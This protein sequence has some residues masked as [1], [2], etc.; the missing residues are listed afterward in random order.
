[1]PRH[2]LTVAG[3]AMFVVG[4]SH[5]NSNMEMSGPPTKPAPAPEMKK[6]SR[7]IGTWT[8]DAEMVGPM[9]EQM[10]ADMK[11]PADAKLTFPGGGTWDWAMDGMFLRMDGWHSMGEGGKMNMI[12]YVMWDPKIGKYR[13]FF[14]SDWGEAGD[15]TLTPSADGNSFTSTARMIDAQGNKSSGTGTM[16]FI[17]NNSMEWTWKE[18]SGLELK[19]TNKR[20]M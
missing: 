5:Q 4:C 16:R 13:S 7:F 8:G 20:Q 17:D 3:L 12:E 9:A 1:M 19:G 6:L 14:L 15:G 11:M 18:S 2:L 10:K